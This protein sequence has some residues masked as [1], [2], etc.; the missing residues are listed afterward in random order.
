MSE[1]ALSYRLNR[2]LFQRDEQ[3]A[4]LVQRVS[5]EFH[6]QFYYPHIG[7]VG[8]SFNP[9][10]WNERID[11]TAGMLRLVFGL[12]TRA[13]DRHDDD[14]T[15]VVALNEPMLRPEGSSDEV[16][17]YSQHVANVLDLR[18]DT[19]VSRSFEQVVRG[20]GELPIAMFASRDTDMERRARDAG[21]RDVFS[22]VLTFKQLLG[23]TRFPDDMRRM[24]SAIAEAYRHPV[25]IE[26]TA[27]FME[28]GAY[29]INV[30][31]CRPFHFAG[32]PVH[33][34][35][36]EDIPAEDL[37]IQTAGPIIGQSVATE[38]DRLIYVVPERYSALSTSERY[39]TAQLLGRVTSAQA[40]GPTVMLIGPG[41][42]GTRMPQLGVPVTLS[43]IKNA[44]VLCEV[45]EMHE[46][47][48]PDLSLGTHFFN[49][50]VDL[51]ILYMGVAPRTEGAVFN[52]ALLS[53]LPNKLAEI[54]PDAADKA[55]LVRVIDT[56]DLEGRCIWL[57]ADSLEQRGAVYVFDRCTVLSPR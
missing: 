1:E 14:Y 23:E 7:G 51:G 32:G 38:I 40:P 34:Q 21:M 42:W 9:Y 28:D 35:F 48:N 17:K 29:R 5:G 27:N 31:Q 18:E 44:T 46:G 41:R 26:F 22:H 49:D 56:A 6:G 39:A 4:L 24:M 50:L 55:D 20:S 15:R 37:L 57:W 54:L 47:L 52:T 10:A 19:H 53:G 25:D 3:M 13:V 45:A 36:P 8:Y 30:L 43:Q 2:G 16:R 33:V 12:G 11:P